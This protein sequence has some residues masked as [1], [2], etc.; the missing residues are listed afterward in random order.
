[1]CVVKRGLLP[2]LLLC[3]CAC[4]EQTGTVRGVIKDAIGGEPLAR[5]DIQLAAG[6][7]TVT[8]DRGRFEFPQV[9]PGD[10]VLRVSTV[11]YRI[12]KKPFSLAALD[13]KEFEVSLSPD[14]FRKTETVVVDA[15][16]F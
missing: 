9:A 16:P 6:I 7:Q 14:T 3:A 15:G 8:D 5:V 1:M 13:I 11:G 10:Y 4:A 12:I 2:L